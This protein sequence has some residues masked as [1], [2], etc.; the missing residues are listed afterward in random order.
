LKLTVRGG[1]RHEKAEETT[2]M[3][4]RSL[5]AIINACTISRSVLPTKLCALLGIPANQIWALSVHAFSILLNCIACAARL[6]WV[7]IKGVK[8]RLNHS[9]AS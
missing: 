4:T 7:Y 5:L 8:L 1:E 6:S 3:H 2:E 9:K